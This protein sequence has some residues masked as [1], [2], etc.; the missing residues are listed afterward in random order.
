MARFGSKWNKPSRSDHYLMRIAQ[1][2]RQANTKNPN[3]CELDD[4]KVIFEPEYKSEEEEQG[5]YT[6]EQIAEQVK[7]TQ[8]IWAARTGLM[9]VKRGE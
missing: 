6:K 7:Q 1:R 8:A 5:V 2:V 9:M 4:E 3:Q